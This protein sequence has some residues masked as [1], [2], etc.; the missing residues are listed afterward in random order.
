MVYPGWEPLI[1]P[2][3]L[4]VGP[5]DP[6]AHFWRWPWEYL[7]YLTLLCGL[8][9]DGFVLELGCNHGRTML[10]LAAYLGPS[11]RY[12]GLD[13]LPRQIEF[14]REAAK[15]LP[16]PANFQVA[17]IFNGTYNPGG[18]QRASTYRFPYPDSSFDV[19]YAASVFTHLSVPSQRAWQQELARV[20]RKDGLLVVTL[21]G[22]LYV[23]LL[24]GEATEDGRRF[25]S[26]GHLEK[27][28]SAEGSNAWGSFHG[29]AFAEE[30]FDAFRLL[31]RFPAGRIAGRRV[32]FPVASLQDVYVFRKR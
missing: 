29:P 18:T 8:R 1:P 27:E 22:S 30:V 23:R 31:A 12:E 13:I 9:R 26:R 5:N 15:S 7:A 3:E 32:L 10:G 17:D 14:A 11:A 21:H 28:R 25:A 6:F 20:L 16:F 19:A 2:R 4:W 24:F